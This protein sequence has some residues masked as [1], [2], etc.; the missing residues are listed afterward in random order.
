MGSLDHRLNGVPLQRHHHFGCDDDCRHFTTVV[1]ATLVVGP[2]YLSGAFALDAARGG[3]VMSSG[4]IVAALTG[5]PAG[6][7]ITFAVAAV[8]IVIALAIASVSHALSRRAVPP[9]REQ[10]SEPLL[11]AHVIA[12]IATVQQGVAFRALRKMG[13]R[14]GSTYSR[15]TSRDQC[16]I[17]QLINRLYC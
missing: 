13:G 16:C 3:L 5:V 7:R 12:A 9:N 8:L 4:P 2:F 1:M 17:R 14:L 11:G 15:H 10:E 6:M